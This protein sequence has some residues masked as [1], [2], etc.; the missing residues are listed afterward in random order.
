MKT[1]TEKAA[2]D[3]AASEKPTD[4][5]GTAVLSN[6][7]AGWLQPVMVWPLV[8]GLAL[9]YAVGRETGSRGPAPA[10]P[11]QAAVAPAPVP[12]AGPAP[13]APARPAGQ[14]T[15]EV[16]AVKLD[17][18]LAAPRKGAKNPKV[19]VVVVSDFQCPFCSRA[20]P[21]LAELEKKYAKDVAFVFLHQPLAFHA[22]ALPAAIAAT[23]AHRQGKFWE[24][25][26]KL[27]S[28]QQSLNRGTFETYAGELKLNLARFR[29][30]LEDPALKEEVLVSSRLATA[31]GANGTPGF[32][33]NGRKLEGAKP[34]ASFEVLIDDEI[35]KADALLAK[36]TPLAEVSK[37]LTEQAVAM[38]N[39]P[40]DVPVGDAPTKGP[41]KAPVTIVAFSEFQCPFC[42]RV[43][44]TLKQ[45]ED[46]YKGKV[47]IAFKHLPL[48][49]HQHAQLAAEASLAA[50]EQGKFWEMHDK[51][52]ANQ[53]AL[54]RPALE[55]YAQ[56]LGLN[57][58]K[59]KAALDSGRYKARV[60]QDAAQ[61]ASLGATGTPTFFINGKKI[62]GA[63]PFDDFKRIIDGELQRGS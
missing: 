13:A 30:D 37:K 44:P 26:D 50:H 57:L 15:T 5:S 49:F 31:A 62:T 55:K 28:N 19:T 41:A 20:V 9:G 8:T 46:T 60:Q 24:M 3:K 7:L 58:T 52:F 48:A 16:A 29:K 53:Q 35:R 22:D 47:R 42:S 34:V 59:F 12:A 38:A 14:P 25:H 17:L 36:G 23:A 27:F 61:A 32:F 54:E 21:T 63:R 33:I 56:E 10:A 51:L 40:I 6:R 11:I 18:P 1:A 39:A 4:G 2:I 45:V 43:T